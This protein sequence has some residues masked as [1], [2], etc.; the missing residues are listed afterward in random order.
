MMK[1]LLTLSIAFIIA[2]AAATVAEAQNRWNIYAGG[3][4]SH[5]C[6]TAPM[7]GS[8]RSFGWGGGAFAGAGYEINFNSHWSLTPQI[9][10]AYSNNGATLSSAEMDFSHNHA[11][12]LSTLNLNIPIIASFRFPVAGEVGLRLGAGPCLYESLAGWHYRPGSTEKESMSGSVADRFNIG[13]TG[14][15][16]VETGW[17]FAYMLRVQYQMLREGWTRRTVG[18]SLGVRYSF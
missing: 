1:R 2:A 9:E 3:N 18:L 4:I 16:A 14:E 5:L 17:H 6:E 7:I 12:W 15:A 11:S 13:V 8:D 10:L